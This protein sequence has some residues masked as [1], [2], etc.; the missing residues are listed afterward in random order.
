M[1]SDVIREIRENLEVR[2][3]VRRLILTDELLSVPA[4]LARVEERLGQVEE[5][6]G[7]IAERQGWTEERQDRME[8][9]QSRMEARQSRMEARQDR[10]EGVQA[11]MA[12]T[13]A[14]VAETQAQMGAILER[15]EIDLAGIKGSVV[16]GRAQRRMVEL[17]SARL[18]L[19][20]AEVIVGPMLPTGASQ[21]FLNACRRAEA[22]AEQLERLRNTDIII[23]GRK[24]TDGAST[25]VYLAVEVAYSLDDR[26]IYRVGE[27]MTIL[28]GLI[29]RSSE[30]DAEVM[31]VVYGVRISDG[32][33]SAAEDRR[34]NVFDEEL[35]R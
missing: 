12:D 9:R 35:P 16:E 34:L 31:G 24:G 7:R 26:D 20:S 14:R 2:E 21:Q 19:H 8:A 11:Q 3:E 33:R 10:M 23:R 30:P 5:H 6:L 17:A 18:G 29:P 32:L 13:L 15:I 28:R 25:P 1:V 4:I 27:S 22:S